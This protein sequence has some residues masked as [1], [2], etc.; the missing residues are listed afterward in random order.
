MTCKLCG[1]G[2][3]SNFGMR[4]TPH[5]YCHACHGHEYEGQLFD[6]KTWDAWVNGEIERPAREEQL[7]MF[8]R[9]A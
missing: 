9:A 8:G 6:R 4:D 1:S 2:N 7:D 5:I 3:T